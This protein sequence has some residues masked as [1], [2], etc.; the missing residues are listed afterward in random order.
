M[1]PFTQFLMPDGRK[2]TVTIERPREIEEF[3]KAIMRR[4][5]RFE[6]EMLS[7]GEVSMEIVRDVPDPDV[8]DLLANEICPNGPPVPEHVDKMIR[9]ALE[10][11]NECE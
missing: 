7:T 2:T 1:I 11:L 3:A 6:I 5:Y 4:G 10:Y 8:D 9:E